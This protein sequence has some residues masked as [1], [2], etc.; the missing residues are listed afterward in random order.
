MR[1]LVSVDF[2]IDSFKLRKAIVSNGIL[3]DIYVTLPFLGLSTPSWVKALVR[4]GVWARGV[5]TVVWYFSQVICNTVTFI[6][7]MYVRATTHCTCTLPSS[8]LGRTT[9]GKVPCSVAR[10]GWWCGAGW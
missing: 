10:L 3:L 1:L 7:A 2:S 9:V 8:Q 5:E 4:L 6:L